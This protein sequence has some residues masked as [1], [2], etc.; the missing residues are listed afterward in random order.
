[1]PP[2]LPPLALI[3]AT[4]PSLGIGLHGT[5]PWPPLKADL[6]FFARVTKRVLPPP[7][8]THTSQNGSSKSRKNAVIMGRKTWESIPAKFRPLRGRINVVVSRRV[9]ALG[10]PAGEA[11]GKEGPVFGAGSVEEGVRMLQRRYPS[12]GA[13]TV[14]QMTSQQ[15]GEGKALGRNKEEGTVE[16]GRIFVIGGAEIYGL[17]L[18]MPDAKRILWTRLRG[19]WE[20]DAFFPGGVLLG[21]GEGEGGDEGKDEG[22]WFR[23]SKEELEEWVGEE[24]V[25]GVKREGEVEFEVFMVEREGG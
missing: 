4:T 23:R 20:C 16:L 2:P 17:A 25:G 14:G 3:V 11:G 8:P 21:E 19:E 13:D 5:L 7:H 10:L 12:S 15:E 24:G 9:E 18:R 22:G 6:A 1:M